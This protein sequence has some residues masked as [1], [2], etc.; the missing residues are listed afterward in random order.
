VISQP[1]DIADRVERVLEYHRASKHT[2]ESVAA[3]KPQTD[4]AAQPGATRSFPGRPKV[5]L[6]TGLLDLSVTAR[7]VMR[8]GLAALPDSHV[9]PPQDLKTLAT[10]LYMA[11]GVTAERSFE[12]HKYRLRTCPSGSALFPGEIY[13]A[14]FA[15]HGLDPGLYSFNPHEFSLTKLREGPQTLA[16]IKRGRPD[17]AFL[18]SVPAVLLVSTIYWRSAWKYRARGF[19]IA[20]LDAGQLVANLIATANGL[21]ITTM[22]RL[23]MNDALM[24]DLIGIPH[25][26]RFD[27]FEA[28]QAMVVWGDSAAVPIEAPGPGGPPHQLS[29]IERSPLGKDVVSYGS[30]VATHFDC[31]AP[32]VPLRDVRPPFT[33]LSPM[34][35]VHESQTMPGHDDA[36]EGPSLRHVLL[37]RRSSRDFEQNS[38]SRDHFLS[39]NHSAF[40]T[41]T[42]DPLHPD[43]PHLGLIRP[44][45]IIHSVVG[46]ASGVWYYHAHTDRWVLL[47]RGTYRPQSQN[48]CIGQPRC[49]NAAALCLMTANLHQ[50]MHGIGPD[51]YRLAN[52]EAGIAGQR[53]ALAAA[54]AGVGSC[55]IGTFYDDEIRAFLGI[56]QTGWEVMYVYTLGVTATE[57][58]SP[59][60]PGLGIG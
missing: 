20:L 13:V 30:I 26:P 21:G 3:L 4:P 12:G 17:L 54:A 39:I 16:H 15:V 40:H 56:A 19:R 47:R 53:L 35:E 7:A 32:G 37:N 58:E 25:D 42:F 41:G 31:V 49:G 2:P 45:W 10:W 33:E 44:Y 51:I 36:Y 1:K 9:H 11:Y 6:P 46:I 43:G 60:F 5:S 29:V 50:T 34:P 55:G 18:K 57:P 27:E 14:A 8:V 24:R 52:L 38:I 28:V 59:R 22:T 23:K 48:L